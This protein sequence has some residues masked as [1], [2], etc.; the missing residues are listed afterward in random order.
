MRFLGWTV[1]AGG[2]TRQDQTFDFTRR[3]DRALQLDAVPLLISLTT[4]PRVWI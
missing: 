1:T 4:M 2:S 3:Q